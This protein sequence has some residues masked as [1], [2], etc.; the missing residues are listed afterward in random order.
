MFRAL[1]RWE[2]RGNLGT[3]GVVLDDSETFRLD[4]MESELV[5]GK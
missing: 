4:K 3:S 2:M 5:G 1:C